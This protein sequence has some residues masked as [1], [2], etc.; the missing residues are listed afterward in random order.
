VVQVNGNQ[1]PVGITAWE[2]I[3]VAAVDRQNQWDKPPPWQQLEKAIFDRCLVFEEQGA[4]AK[5]IQ[6]QSGEHQPE[7]SEPDR[8]AAEAAHFG[9]KRLGDGNRERRRAEHNK[10]LTRHNVSSTRRIQFPAAC[11]ARGEL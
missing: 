3:T 11:E 4:L 8:E 2:A 1:A 7:P 6:H 9:I 10:A 5:I